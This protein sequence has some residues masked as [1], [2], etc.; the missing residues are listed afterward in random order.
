MNRDIYFFR[1]EI[2][3]TSAARV[4]MFCITVDGFIR[5]GFWIAGTF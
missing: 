1:Q 5:F 2:R 3:M 4:L